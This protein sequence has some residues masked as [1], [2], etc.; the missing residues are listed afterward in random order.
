M[1][2][3]WPLL[4]LLLRLLSLC[5]EATHGVRLDLSFREL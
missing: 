1:L 2:D 5:K 4:E 3:G